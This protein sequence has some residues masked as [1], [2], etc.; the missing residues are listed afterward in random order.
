MAA[1]QRTRRLGM[2]RIR[3][4]GETRIG[5]VIFFVF[6]AAVAWAAFQ[7]VPVVY[8]HYDLVDKVNEIC[9]TPR[10][11]IRGNPDEYITSQLMKE[12]DLREMGQWIGPNAFEITTTDHNRRIHL[13]YERQ[14]MILPK[15]PYTFKWD[16]T[17]DQPLL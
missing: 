12:V 13:Y 17:A 2:R 10:Y 6:L 9:R 16:F 15:V 14:A 8:Q 11:Q 7:I 4:A 3:E 5:T 1:Q